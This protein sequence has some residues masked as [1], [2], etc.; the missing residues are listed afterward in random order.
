MTGGIKRGDRAGTGDLEAQPTADAD[1]TGSGAGP[2]VTG[3]PSAGGEN[4]GQ[5]RL[6]PGDTNLDELT[7]KDASDPDL[8]LT[9]IGEV[10]PEDW[11]ANTG[12]THSEEAEAPSR[13]R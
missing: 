10:P 3:D 8:G 13:K 2:N 9:D 7:V 12:P 4:R 1:R 6:K 11:A 5:T